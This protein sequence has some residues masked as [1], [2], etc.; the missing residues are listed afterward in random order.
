LAQPGRPTQRA[1]SSWPAKRRAARGDG[2]RLEVLG[3]KRRL[4]CG[5]HRLTVAHVVES[6]QSSQPCRSTIEDGVAAQRLAEATTESWQIRRV[7][8]L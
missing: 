5:N 2:Q 1:G 3:S 6:L 8:R 7:V 4:Q